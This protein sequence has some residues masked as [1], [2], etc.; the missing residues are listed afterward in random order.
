[1]WKEQGYTSC[2]ASC[3]GG[4]EELI[5]NCVREDT[6]KVASPFLCSPET[7]PEARIRTCNDRP[8]PPRWNYSDYSPCS[9]SCGIGVR[10]R[11]V[12]CIHEV[13]RGGENTMVVPDSM[14]PQ[15]PPS[16]RQYCNI[17]D[18]PVRWEVSAWSKCNKYVYRC[19]L[20]GIT[21]T[22]QQQ[23]ISFIHRPCGGGIKQRKV[24][25]KQIMAQEHKVERRDEL[26]PSMKPAATKEC[27][28]KPCAPEDHRPPIASSNTTYIQHDPKKT[29]VTLK[30]GGAATVFLGTQIKIKCPVKRFA[31]NRNHAHHSTARVYS[32]RFIPLEIVPRPFQIQS[33]EN[34]LEQELE[35]S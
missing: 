25:C 1:M 27:N 12:Q 32:K 30:I 17:L 4:I 33:H 18:C 28:T 8:C 16:Q 24:E 20:R 34:T 23:F 21:C 11:E 35:L 9:K 7:K 15:P 10:E 5:I 14:C 22:R 3:L 2:S 29:K 26:C 6:G 13:T 19:G 31:T